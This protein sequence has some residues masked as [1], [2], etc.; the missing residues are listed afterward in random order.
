MKEAT[1]EFLCEIEALAAKRKEE[2]RNTAD[3]V[4]IKGTTYY[5]SNVGND[6]NDG[7]TPQ[8]AWKTLQKISSADLKFG[9]GVRLKRGD[10]FRGCIYAK[11]GVTYCAYGKG[12]KP[13]L[14]SWDKNLAD[15]SLWELYNAEHNIWKLKE[16]ILDCGT[17]ILN[18]DEICCYRHA[19]SYVDGRFVCRYEEDKEFIVEKEL[20]DLECVCFFTDKMTTAPTIRADKIIADF[21]VPDIDNGEAYGEL[22]FRC[23][24]GNPGEV[25]DS[26]EPLARRRGVDFDDKNYVT[27]DNL[28]L[29]YYGWHAIAG[30][31]CKHVNGIRISNCEIGWIGGS[32]HNYYGNDPNYPQGGRG[33]VGRLGNG[34]E[35]YGGCDDYVVENCYIYQNY[36]CA[37][38]HQ[39]TT[40]GKHYE[41]KNILYKDN[42]IEYCVYGIEYFLEMNCGDTDSFMENVEMCG[43]IIRY[44][45]YGWGQQ[46]HNKHTPSLIKGWS[47]Y[48]RG[49]N[50]T[51]HHNIFDRSAYRMIH[52]VARKTEYCPTLHDNT[53]IQNEGGMLGQW[54]GNGEK[55]PETVMFSDK[56]DEIIEDVYGDKNAKA[57]IVRKR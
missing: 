44:G 43:N 13:E 56:V 7:L 48:N 24:K 29:K 4:E 52:L 9:D 12:K 57:Y 33:T 2:I 25:F 34:V 55:E 30:G 8:T 32:I 23:D 46:R 1:K 37:I 21:P 49:F 20:E 19:P 45:G 35:I 14:R 6:E 36:D 3:N 10:I 16:K 17:L 26:I 39:I 54:G 28:C 31:A 50:Q 22:Y 27:V 11:E 15:A 5:V 53:Y 18:D 47:F 40:Y 38:T 51:I 41:L 42:L